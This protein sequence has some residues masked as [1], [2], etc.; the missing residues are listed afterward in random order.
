MSISLQNVAKYAAIVAIVFIGAV[1]ILP[2]PAA[3]AFDIPAS[4]VELEGF[5]WG[6][7]GDSAKPEGI[8]W[9]SMNCSNPIPPS[10]PNGTCAA[11]GGMIML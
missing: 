2:Q 5:A 11:E 8:G 6:A 1:F 4:G 9:I 7:Y 10:L 3:A